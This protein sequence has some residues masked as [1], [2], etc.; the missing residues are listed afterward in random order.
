[1]P[2][3]PV[4]QVTASYWFISTKGKFQRIEVSES[5]AAD[6]RLS[7]IMGVVNEGLTAGAFPQVPGEDQGG[8]PKRPAFS[9][10]VFCDYNRVCPTGRDQ[11]Y[12]RKKEQPGAALH[13]GLELR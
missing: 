3:P 11:I 2:V 4:G 13:Q 8:I 12:E 1:M 6:Q 9:N 10:C 5:E 7:E